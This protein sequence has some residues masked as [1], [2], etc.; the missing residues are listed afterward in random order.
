MSSKAGT[1]GNIAVRGLCVALI[2]AGV[3]TAFAANNDWNG[4]SA[5]GKRETAGNWSGGAPDNT[6]Q[7]RV[8][9]GGTYTV[10]VDQT[11]VDDGDPAT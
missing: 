11:T 9:Q 3:G 1:G 7:I 10:T 2:L 6:D 4:N 5:D 8:I